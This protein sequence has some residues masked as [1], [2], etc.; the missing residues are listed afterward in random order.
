MNCP[1]NGWGTVFQAHVNPQSTY[2]DETGDFGF[3]IGTRL[4]TDGYFKNSP[5]FMQVLL[6]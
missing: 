6:A 4:Y 3:G 1:E 2:N 5:L